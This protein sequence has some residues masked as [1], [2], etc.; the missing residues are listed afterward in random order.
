[1]TMTVLRP[2][3]DLLEIAGQ[4]RSLKPAETKMK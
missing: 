4:A 2:I 1:L 3:E